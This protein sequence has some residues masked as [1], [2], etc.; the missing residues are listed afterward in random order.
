ML[1]DPGL[2]LFEGSYD[3][4]KLYIAFGIWFV[5]CL[6]IPPQVKSR[7]ESHTV[8]SK[9]EKLGSLILMSQSPREQYSDTYLFNLK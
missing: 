8:P 3:N 6:P 4:G 9:A 5:S 7:W 1:V 2:A